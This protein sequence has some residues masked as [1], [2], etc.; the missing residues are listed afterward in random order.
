ML[1]LREFAEQ[2]RDK[3]NVT[4]RR[5]ENR[6]ATIADYPTEYQNLDNITG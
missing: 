3:I 5:L 2:Q 4:V 1:N 6:T